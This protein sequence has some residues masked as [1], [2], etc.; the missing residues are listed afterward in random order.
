[1]KYISSKIRD[2]L[3]KKIYFHQHPETAIRYYPIVKII[4]ENGWLSDKILEVG[5]GSIGIA[6]YIDSQ[7]V[8][9]DNDFSEPDHPNLIKVKGNGEKLPFK[10]NEFTVAILS[11]VLEHVPKKNRKK[12][13]EETIR[14]TKKA[15]IISGPFGNEAFQQDKALSKLSEHHFFKEHLLYGLPD[16]AEIEKIK[17]RYISEITKIGSFLNLNI[18]YLI[19]RLFTSKN[20]FLYYLYLKGLM[21]L[22]PFLVRCNKPP[23]YRTVYLIGL[24]K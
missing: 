7:V 18:R 8:G 5:S 20:K 11:D 17:N 6:A 24:N 4:K 9:V 21:P 2:F 23:Q 14:V 12:L 15:V 13:I 19:M 22:V 10:K 3:S 16:Y 1:M